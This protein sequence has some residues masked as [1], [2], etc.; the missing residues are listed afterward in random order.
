[1]GL[2]GEGRREKDKRGEW[3]VKRRWGDGGRGQWS[4]E[5]AVMA[6]RL[7]AGHSKNLAFLHSELLKTIIKYHFF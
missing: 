1:L 6:S 5:E 3:K 7:T 2:G 4:V